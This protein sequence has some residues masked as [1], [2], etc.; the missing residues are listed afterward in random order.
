M[1]LNSG[2]DLIDAANNTFSDWLLRTNDMSTLMREDVL[3]ANSTVA[4]T[5][6]DARLIGSFVANTVS[7]VD[8]LQG[9]NL[10]V[11]GNISA[12]LLTISSNATFDTDCNL[13]TVANTLT[14]DRQLNFGS[15]NTGFENVIA[16]TDLTYTVGN[17][18]YQFSE[19]HFANIHITHTAFCANLDVSYTPNLVNL[20]VTGNLSVRDITFPDGGMFTA[21]A[22]TTS[23]STFVIDQFDK[24]TS[25]GFKYIIHGVNSDASSV[26][27]LELMCGHNDTDIFF[28]RY[29]EL[30]NNFDAVI[31]PSISG[32]NVVLS[33][34]C[35]SATGA[36]T[37][38]FNIVRIET[39]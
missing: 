34:T 24:T 31:T 22:S 33:A 10:D 39:R 8:S 17:T 3:T 35:D 37:H 38:S 2:F 19:G 13:V 15:S 27:T 5:N 25:K 26:F 23:S 4:N 9:G 20:D 32:A 6:G 1:A 30:T 36:N 12:A 7:V 29:G 14:V 11:S 18:T 16:N 21:N 28:T